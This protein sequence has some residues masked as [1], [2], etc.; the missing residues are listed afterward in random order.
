MRREPRQ[1]IE[2]SLRHARTLLWILGEYQSQ[3]ESAIGSSEN[4][5]VKVA[6]LRKAWRRAQ[7]LVS[8]IGVEIRRYR[9]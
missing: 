2:L 1:I 3:V 7:Y 4:D 8:T 5:R 9:S 6:A